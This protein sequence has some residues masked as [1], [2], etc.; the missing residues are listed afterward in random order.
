VSDTRTFHAATAEDMEALGGRLARAAPP[1]TRLHLAGELAAGKTTL[2]RGYLRALGHAGA[3]K[4]P[5]FTLVE[6]YT[7]ATRSVHHFDLY[8]MAGGELEFIGFEDYLEPDADLLIEWAEKGGDA[9]SAPDLDLRLRVVDDGREVSIT[10]RT[11][12]GEAVL[13]AL[14]NA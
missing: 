3:V 5:T 2:A 7:L 8:R 6:T 9:L 4:S 1:G 11:A 10:P 12:R 14:A 13:D